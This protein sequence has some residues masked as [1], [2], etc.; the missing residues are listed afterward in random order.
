MESIDDKILSKLQKCGRGVVFSAARFAHF[1][2][3][4]AVRK[5][6]V[7]LCNAETIIRIAQGIYCFPVID[8]ELGLGIIYPTFDEI[9]SY[10]A[11]RDKAQ[12]APAGAY[13]INKLGLSTQV[14]MNAVFLT[15]GES[16]KIKMF[17]GRHIVFKHAAP[18]NFAFK[19]SFAQ[20]VCIALKDIG[21]DNLTDEQT[22]ALKK[23]ILQVPKIAE[24]DLILMPDW[25][26]QLLKMIYDE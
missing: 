22:A 9:A 8:K 26:K 16:R 18:K 6:V 2:S 15:S 17:N 5:A 19:N 7:R 21:K 4:E 25:I 13:A 23:I 24:T 1:G 10:I 11:K 20:L 3:T 12:I 14:P